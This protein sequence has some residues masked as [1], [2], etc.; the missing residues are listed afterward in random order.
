MEEQINFFKKRIDN[1]ETLKYQVNETFS[2]YMKKLQQQSKD[3]IVKLYKNGKEPVNE[4]I[5]NNNKTMHI[6]Y[7]MLDEMNKVEQTLETLN[8]NF[9]KNIKKLKN[10][11][12]IIEK[13]RKK[14]IAV[15][16]RERIESERNTKSQLKQKQNSPS[17]YAEY[18]REY[19]KMRNKEVKHCDF[20]N[21][22]ISYYAWSKHNKTLKHL[23]NSI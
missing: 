23:K 15:Q 1:I 2:H 11:L 3:D 13:E 4:W 18:N 12:E 21:E 9:D 5:L 22:E 8:V 14:Q 19:A 20:C 17:K 10:E 7:E 6:H 16:E